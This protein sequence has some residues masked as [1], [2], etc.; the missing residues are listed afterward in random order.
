MAKKNTLK[1]V[2]CAHNYSANSTI[3]VSVCIFSTL[4]WIHVLRCQPNKFRIQK[5][6]NNNN[7]KKDGDLEFFLCPMPMTRQKM[8]FTKKN[9]FDNQVLLWLLIIS[10]I[11]MTVMSGSG[12]TL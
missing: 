10:F 6:R 4:V 11:L 7:K 1:F 2:I 9:L 3:S 12:V 5:M 8:S